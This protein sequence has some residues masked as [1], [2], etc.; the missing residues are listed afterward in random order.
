[1]RHVGT[2]DFTW[3]D[4]YVFVKTSGWD[5]ALTREMYPEHADWT[6]ENM[7][8]AEVVDSL[9]WLVWAKTENGSKN[10]NQPKPIPRPGVEEPEKR[11]KG[12]AVPIDQMKA[13]MEALRLR[14]RSS[15][16]EEQ[17]TRISVRREVE[18]REKEKKNGN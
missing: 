9:H 11:V 4:L 16:S 8:L 12:E 3:R 14:L 18:K 5:D 7:L 10:R 15:T 13:K 1:M 6:P 2:D 17:V